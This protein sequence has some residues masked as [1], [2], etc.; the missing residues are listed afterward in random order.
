MSKAERNEARQR[1]LELVKPCAKKRGGMTL[2]VAHA[3]GK[4]TPYGRTDYLDVTLWGVVEGK[5][6]QMFWLSSLYCTAFGHRYNERRESVSMS[7]CGFSKTHQIAY[8][9]ARLVG[10]PIRVEASGCGP[11][12][13]P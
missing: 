8:D 13:K 5:P 7:G 3:D 6:C 12:V 11:W 10:K 2:Y 1:L 9:L 4:P